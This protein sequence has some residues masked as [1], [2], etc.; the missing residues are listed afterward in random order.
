VRVVVF[1]A[2]G[3]VGSRVVE[4][5]LVRGHEV[6]AFARD[7]EAVFEADGLTVVSGDARDQ[8]SVARALEGADGVISVMGARGL[9]PT[10]ELSDATAG[11]IATMQERGPRRLVLLSHVGVLLKKVD[12]QYEHVVAEHR[13]N[14]ETVRASGLDW[15]AVCP[16]GITGSPGT[17]KVQ[18]V[19]GARAPEWTIAR[20]DLV[21]F[22][23]DQLES[24]EHLHQ[25]VG[26]SG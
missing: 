13:R 3:R 5:A 18:A 6:V 20:A 7:P 16:P 11:V 4:G 8:E 24:D 14:F 9:D 21:G 10:T 26:V 17:G 12:P 23:L 2:T 25:A 19:P 22:L 1:G 15:V